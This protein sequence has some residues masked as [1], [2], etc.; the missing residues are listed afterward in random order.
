M[1]GVWQRHHKV[2]FRA[3]AQPLRPKGSALSSSAQNRGNVSRAVNDSDGGGI[4]LFFRYFCV[5]PLSASSSF[6]TTYFCLNHIDSCYNMV[7]M[8]LSLELSF[9][10]R[11]EP[12]T[13][14]PEGLPPTSSAVS[15]PL[16]P[17]LPV[18]A[19]RRLSFSVNS[20]L[21]SSDVPSVLNPNPLPPT[22]LQSA[23]S[24]CDALTPLDSA[25]RLL[26]LQTPFLLLC[27]PQGERYVG[28]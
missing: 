14:R 3:V 27:S 10:L 18:L 25:D 21:S 5:L 17:R 8:T 19:A 7:N 28:K 24:S 6:P 11:D 15:L 22:P 2:S 9:T 26:C 12:A 1:R 16:Y 23:F 13:R 20:V 4:C